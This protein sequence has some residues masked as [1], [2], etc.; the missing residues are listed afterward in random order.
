MGSTIPVVTI[1]KPSFG[2]S[3]NGCGHCCIEEVCYYGLQLGDDI[4]CKALLSNNDGSYSCGLIVSPYS[5]IS[6]EILS[7]WK[8][9]D[10]VS[11]DYVG[12]DALRKHYIS[13]LSAGKSCDSSD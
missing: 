2:D 5:Y 12:E 4:H 3:C 8:K 9:I 13:S 11:G 6:S 10:E 7:H 1:E